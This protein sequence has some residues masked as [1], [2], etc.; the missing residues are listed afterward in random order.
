MLSL[1]RSALGAASLLRCWLLRHKPDFH[2]GIQGGSDALQRSKTGGASA[3]QPGNGW[4]LHASALCQS[5]LG[6]TA[7]LAQV[8]QLAHE[9]KFFLQRIISIFYS[10][11]F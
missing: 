8:N 11:V 9:R 10:W 2:L 1:A 7:L 5:L 6:E 4:L 3:F